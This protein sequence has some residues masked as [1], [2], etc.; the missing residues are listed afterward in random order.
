MYK[1]VN[2]LGEMMIRNEKKIEI[3]AN[4]AEQIKLSLDF[5]IRK[6]IKSD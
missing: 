6:F 3:M 4:I 5:V 2:I 1:Q